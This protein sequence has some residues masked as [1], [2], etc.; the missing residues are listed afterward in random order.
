M[1]QQQHH[2]IQS[3][4]QFAHN[5]QLGIAA[6]MPAFPPL[7]YY[8]MPP[9]LKTIR[10][11]SP[12]SLG[13]GREIAVSSKSYAAFY[14]QRGYGHVIRTVYGMLLNTDFIFY[15]LSAAQR[16]LKKS[17]KCKPKRVTFG[18]PL[19]SKVYLSPE[20]VPCVRISQLCVYAIAISFGKHCYFQSPHLC[21]FNSR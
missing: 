2:G 17:Q 4:P 13:N 8:C 15:F 10:E 3:S 6:P 11:V 14:D 20:Y 9:S 7:P 12:A 16:N 18:C 5:A 1:L 19:Q 21:I